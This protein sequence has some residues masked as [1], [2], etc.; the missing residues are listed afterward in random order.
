LELVAARAATY[1]RPVVVL[2][3]RWTASMGEGLAA[4]LDGLGRVTV[5]GARMA[6]LLGGTCGYTLPH[7]GHSASGTGS[8]ERYTKA[9]AVSAGA[10]PYFSGAIVKLAR[11]WLTLRTAAE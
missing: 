3:D 7:S 2:V 8:P 10:G 11:P 9:S 4:G 5:V 6:G 1:P